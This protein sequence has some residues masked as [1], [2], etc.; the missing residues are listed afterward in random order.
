ME[1]VYN[2]MEKEFRNLTKDFNRGL[3]EIYIIRNSKQS[4]LEFR[5]SINIF[6][7]EKFYIIVCYLTVGLTDMYTRV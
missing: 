6:N 3:L 7:L 5:A 2:K 4:S 1:A